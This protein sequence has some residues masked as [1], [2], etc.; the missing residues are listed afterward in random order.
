MTICIIMLVAMVASVGYFFAFDFL[1]LTEN[2]K[3]YIEETKDIIIAECPV[4]DKYLSA[5]AKEYLEIS[6]NIR[7]SFEE[8]GYKIIIKENFE[9][10]KDNKSA[11]G[12]H[13][14][15]NKIICIDYSRKMSF[16]I[17]FFIDSKNK[18]VP[19]EIG[20]Y[21][22]NK[23]GATDTT[24]WH[25]ICYQENTDKYLKEVYSPDFYNNYAKKLQISGETFAVFFS[26]IQNRKDIK[27]KYPEVYDYITECA[28]KI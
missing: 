26:S 13:N 9:D 24:K 23:V 18:L 12:F 8:D 28:N 22:D 19:H 6:E 14:S 27:E 17:N 5:V 16:Y 20:H 2:E 15:K 25:S 4:S 3:E 10:R 21:V 7:N 11:L 1:P